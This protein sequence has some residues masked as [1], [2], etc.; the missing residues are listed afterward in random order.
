MSFSRLRDLRL[1][2]DQGDLVASKGTHQ[3]RCVKA[4]Y[5]EA[6]SGNPMLVLRYEI[7]TPGEEGRVVFDNVVLIP[8]VAFRYTRVFHAFGIKPDKR[9]GYSGLSEDMFEGKRV[10]LVV[11]HED[12]EGETRARVQE[13]RPAGAERPAPVKAKTK[14]K[15]K[16]E[17]EI[18]DEIE[19][20]D[21]EVVEE[22]APKPKK[23][24]AKRKPEPEP[25]P[26]ED[27][28]ED[29]DDADE[30]DDDDDDDIEDDLPF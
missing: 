26:E 21:E 14:A 7:L 12:W 24:K 29:E 16:P 23:R 6:K 22:E 18:E 13:V 10:V 17:P 3:A 9:G 8:S 27:E 15:A 2:A 19:D 20:E 4:E 30:V 5:K 28:D 11:N 25:E 1:D